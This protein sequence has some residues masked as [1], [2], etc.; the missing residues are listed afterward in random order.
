MAKRVAFMVV[1][2]L[3]G[4]HVPPYSILTPPPGLPFTEIRAGLRQ[5]IMPSMA[6]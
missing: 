1:F 6:R 2:S 3:E 4:E 5:G